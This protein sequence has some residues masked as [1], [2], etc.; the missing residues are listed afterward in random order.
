MKVL[1]I[2]DSPE[3]VEAVALCLQLR[4]PETEVSVAAEGA[5]GI[6]ML[7]ASPVDIVILDINLPDFDGFRVLQEVRTFSDVP[8]IILTVRGKDEDQ[9]RG[10]EI[11]ADDYIVKPFKPR[12][13]VARVNAVLRRTTGIKTVNEKPIV[14]RGKLTLDLTNNEVSL[15]DKKSKLT[16]T[17]AKLLYILMENPEDTLTGDKIA[18]QVWGKEQSDTDELRTYIRR[19]RN[20]L[21]DNPPRII[22]TDYGE[23]YKFVTPI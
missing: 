2:E 7:R 20:K 10:L 8:T 22:L 11:G 16:P 23:G 14:V 3:I 1:I 19:L 15:R 13:L 9:T 17:E 21:K 4:W 18:A 6:E 12:D 5:R